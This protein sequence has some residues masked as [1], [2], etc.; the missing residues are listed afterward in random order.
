MAMGMTSRV[1][2]FAV[3]CLGTDTNSLDIHLE[4]LVHSL[5]V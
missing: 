2:L 3:L 4:T 1:L 5:F